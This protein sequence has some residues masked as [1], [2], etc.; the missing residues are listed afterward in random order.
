MPRAIARFLT[1]SS[2]GFGRRMLSCAVFFSNSN[3]TGVRPERSY[4]LRSAV[5]TKRS[6]AASV[7]KVGIFFFIAHDLL[8][9]HVTGG[10]R[11]N[12]ARPATLADGEDQK[13]RSAAPG[14]ADCPKPALG[15]RARLVRDH[16]S[17]G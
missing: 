5:S 13:D 11:A 8:P 10:N 17:A 4:S 6:A 12:Q 9:V 1:A 7:L 3:L 2:K 15:S 16:D 14:L